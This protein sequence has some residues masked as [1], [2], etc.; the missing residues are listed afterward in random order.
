LKDSVLYLFVSETSRD[1]H[2]DITDRLTGA[3]LKL[4]LPA[5]RTKLMLLDRATGAVLASYAGPDWPA[6]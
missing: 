4:A 1:E 3:N 2:V 5:L 6:D